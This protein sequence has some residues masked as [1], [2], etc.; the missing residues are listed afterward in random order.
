VLDVMPV[1]N[2]MLAVCCPLPEPGACTA[3]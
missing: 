2:M 3:H 1:M